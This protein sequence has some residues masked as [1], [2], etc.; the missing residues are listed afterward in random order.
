[1][2][3]AAAK[4]S[5]PVVIENDGVE[6]RA[7]EI[8]GAGRSE[9]LARAVVDS[10]NLSDWVAYRALLADAFRYTE[11]ASGHQIDDVDQVL[12]GWRRVKEAFPDA[13]AEIIDILVRSD[14]TIVGVVWRATHTGPVRTTEGLESPSYKRIMVADVVALTW[15]DEK[16]TAERHNIGFPSVVEPMLA[17]TGER[18]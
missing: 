5:A 12:A 11:A 7:V 15:L 1:V 18:R 2:V 14:T 8:G 9:E 6:L 17:V 13:S 3:T 4:E 16:I 10:W